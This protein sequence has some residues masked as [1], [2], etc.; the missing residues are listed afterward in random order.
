[1]GLTL[2]SIVC[3]NGQCLNILFIEKPREH[4]MMLEEISAA[5]KNLHKVYIILLNKKDILRIV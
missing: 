3:P 5:D 4:Y 1:M 2:E